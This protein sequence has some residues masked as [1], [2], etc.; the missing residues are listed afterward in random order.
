M[1]LFY[2]PTLS[3]RAEIAELPEEHLAKAIKVIEGWVWE[4]QHSDL[5]KTKETSVQGPFLFRIFGD[6]LG[7]EQAGG[8]FETH[9][10]VAELGIKQDS[11][12]AGLGFYM[13]TLKTTR[14]V[15]ELKDA[16]TSLDKKQIGR[17]RNETPVEQA[18]RYASKEDSCKWIIV[19]NFKEIRLY[20]KFRSTDYFEPFR[21][22]EL[23]DPVRFREFYYLMSRENL[24]TE[25]GN[26]IIDEL[27]GERTE[28]TRKITDEFYQ[29]YHIRRQNLFNDLVKSNPTVGQTLLLEKA[30][31]I[32]DRLIF[33]CF[34]EDSNVRLLPPK[35]IENVLKAAASSFEQ[36]DQKLWRLCTGLFRAIDK[37]LPDRK[38]PINAYNGGLFALDETLDG[39]VVHDDVLEPILRLHEYDFESDLDVNVLGHVFERSVSDLE[40]IRAEIEGNEIAKDESKRKK[41]GIYYTP[42]YITKYIVERT[43]GIYLEKHP[44]RLE[45]V[46][47]LDPACGSGAFLN[48]AHTFLK[49]AYQTRGAEIATAAISEQAEAQ[50]AAASRSKKK[51][52]QSL[53][54]GGLLAFTESGVEVRHDLSSAW[55]YVNDAALLRHIF[56]VDLNEESAE[57]TKLSLWLKTAKADEPLRNLDDNIKIG[58]SLIDDRAVAGMKAFDWTSEFRDIVDAGGFDI[59]IGNPPWVFTRGGKLEQKD[60][61]YFYGHYEVAEYQLNLYALFIE[62]SFKQLREGGRFGF[63]VPNTWLTIPSYETL[64]RFILA[65]ASDVEIVNIYDKVFEAA[66]VDCCLVVF[67]K[68]GPTIVEFAEMRDQQ[69]EYVAPVY[70]ESISALPG[71]IMNIGKFKELESQEILQAINDRAVPLETYAK[72]TTGIKAY[73]IGK[74]KPPQ[75]KEVKEARVF[76]AS[77]QLDDTYVPYLEGVDVKRYRLD[78]ENRTW[79]SYG[80]YLAEPRRSVDFTAPRILVRQIPSKPP[81]CISAAY[82][83][84]HYINDI[85]SMVVCEFKVAPEAILAVLNSRLISFWFVLTYDKLQR[86]LFPQFKVKELKAFPM[87]PDLEAS[88]EQLKELV[89]ELTAGGS[90]IAAETDDAIEFMS[91]N[92]GLPRPLCVKALR[93]V[94]WEVAK[95]KVK[96]SEREEA[97]RYLMTKGKHLAALRESL[98]SQSAAL[99]EV[100]YDLFGLSDDAKAAVGSWELV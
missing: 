94:D 14:V 78:W 1:R 49:D 4:L 76:H 61:D 58:N 83:E 16:H 17:A 36:D 25:V 89:G 44:D 34:C 10:L 46:R 74:G 57:I 2:G 68:G 55:A 56:G 43:L 7:Y 45:S 60:K 3:K 62:R 13:A 50:A 93:D 31:R 24:I 66:N 20:S 53:D 28:R 37:G 32:L 42:P 63:I 67:T 5:D 69:F 75:T 71:A 18:F 6:C 96:S 65:N 23:T 80:D 64:R 47:I 72:V 38:P 9:H 59:V 82:T 29:L 70:P 54:V 95:P 81:Y 21:L 19:S 51:R 33:V 41:E 30:Q 92:F 100:V 97:F 11:A 40:T 88:E 77:S 99:D 84:E 39:L 86:G 26:S 52:Q 15:V 98:V 85:N 73:Q 12:D 48:Q 90:V 8:G 22:E 35:T 27:L 87:P 79:I 91:T